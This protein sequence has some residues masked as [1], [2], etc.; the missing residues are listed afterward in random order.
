M[1][2]G[3]H[4]ERVIERFRHPQRARYARETSIRR[5]LTS[6]GAKEA[7]GC[8]LSG[9]SKPVT[10][11]GTVDGDPPIPVLGRRFP[12]DRLSARVEGRW[13]R[14]SSETRFEAAATAPGTTSVPRTRPF[15]GPVGRARSNP[16]YSNLTSPARQNDAAAA[17]G[18]NFYETY[19]TSRSVAAGATSPLKFNLA[20]RS[21]ADRSTRPVRPTGP[22]AALFLPLLLLRLRF[23][24][25]AFHVGF[26][27]PIQ[28]GASEPNYYDSS[29][30]DS[31]GPFDLPPFSMIPRYLGRLCC[32]G[33][34]IDANDR[35][36]AGATQQPY[37]RGTLTEVLA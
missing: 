23:F 15:G 36:G 28:R 5:H 7:A 2:P 21:G 24:F 9:Q 29:P 6:F 27:I 13:S 33:S 19:L 3:L 20:G 10:R 25:S 8:L 16:A 14:S 26:S 34:S 31:V 22:S 35:V 17:T 11:N 12:H 1:I 37:P 30:P 4:S 18:W 32:P